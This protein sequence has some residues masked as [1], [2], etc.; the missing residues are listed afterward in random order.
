MK[1]EV[2]IQNKHQRNAI[3]GAKISR[4]QEAKELD[5]NHKDK[6]ILIESLLNGDVPSDDSHLK[7]INYERP[8]N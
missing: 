1:F 2:M 8:M 4:K 7:E 3:D 6:Q 5:K